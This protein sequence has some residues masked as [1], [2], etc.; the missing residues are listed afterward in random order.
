MGV[1]PNFARKHAMLFRNGCFDIITQE[2]ID[3]PSNWFFP[4]AIRAEYHPEA[5]VK[6]SVFNR[7]ISQLSNHDEETR[8]L[9]M[10]FLAYCL[11]P[12]APLK[13]LF[14]L[15]PEHDTGK[16]LILE[17]L[18]HYIGEEQTT[19]IPLEK[20]HQHFAVA[21]IVGKSIAFSMELPSDPLPSKATIVAKN[22]T[23]HDKIQV[24]QKYM[25]A[26]KYR[27]HAKIICGTNHAPL[28]CTKRRKPSECEY[29]C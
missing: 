11:M 1:D 15:G 3:P 19:T 22:I 25:K 16:S 17:W 4:F 18:Q 12:G 6:C 23:G 13:K 5:D 20:Y 28:H 8:Q 14:V 27:T 9:F 26:F 29:N 10:A 21:D 7:F 24:Q 2:R